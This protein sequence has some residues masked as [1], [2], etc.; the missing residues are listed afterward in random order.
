MK[1]MVKNLIKDYE[2]GDIK[3]RV[4]LNEDACADLQFAFRGSTAEHN[5]VSSSPD[6]TSNEDPTQ[7]REQ[8]KTD[9]VVLGSRVDLVKEE[10]DCHKDEIDRKVV[11]LQES[12]KDK[13]LEYFRKVSDLEYRV[14]AW[15]SVTSSRLSEKE[16]KTHNLQEAL[17]TIV[18]SLDAHKD[19]LLETVCALSNV[20]ETHCLERSEYI[21]RLGALETDVRNI[22]LDID[23]KKSLIVNLQEENS[24]SSGKNSSDGVLNLEPNAKTVNNLCPHNA[25]H[26]IGAKDECQDTR[27]LEDFLNLE[28]EI[29]EC[30]EKTTDNLLNSSEG[31]NVLLGQ[32]EQ[33]NMRACQILPDEKLKDATQEDKNIFRLEEQ[34]ILRGNQQS[35]DVV[36]PSPQLP[37]PAEGTVKGNH[38]KT[39]EERVELFST[40]ENV[41]NNGNDDIITKDKGGLVMEALATSVHEVNI[42]MRIDDEEFSSVTN[43][44]TSSFGSTAS[45]SSSSSSSSPQKGEEEPIIPLVVVSPSQEMEKNDQEKDNFEDYFSISES[46]SGGI[47]EIADVKVNIHTTSLSSLSSPLTT[48]NSSTSLERFTTEIEKNNTLSSNLSS[49]NVIDR[50]VNLLLLQGD[51]PNSKLP[52]ELEVISCQVLND[53]DCASIA[54]SLCESLA[55]FSVEISSDQEGIEDGRTKNLAAVIRANDDEI[56]RR[57]CEHQEQDGGTTTSLSNE[58]LIPLASIDYDSDFESEQDSS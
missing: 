28:E 21:E 42:S 52:E 33:L 46:I 54:C 10:V 5:C 15:Q 4:K 22:H 38:I 31:R 2:I 16:K 6:N 35:D 30:G 26:K 17:S 56:K 24:T 45:S 20:E 44:V 7:E 43:E 11:E 39:N 19:K 14:S 8:I 51:K 55:S 34:R 29:L 1:I 3:E 18:K 47:S 41:S 12:T 36:L 40:E 13:L 37:L 25:T 27:G 58:E 53:E 9:V 49:R 48:R 50:N 32:E 23:D 57:K